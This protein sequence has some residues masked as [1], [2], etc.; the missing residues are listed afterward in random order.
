M[1]DLPDQEDGPE[2]VPK[3]LISSAYQSTQL[4]HETSQVFQGQRQAQQPFDL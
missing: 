3:L 1:T 2:H 4:N